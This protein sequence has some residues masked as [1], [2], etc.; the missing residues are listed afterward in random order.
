MS[1]MLKTKFRVKDENHSIQIQ[2]ALFE[3]G[4]D[5]VSYNIPYKTPQYTRK[6]YLYVND[7]GQ[8][9]HGDSLSVFDDF[10]DYR[11]MRIVPVT[12]FEFV[13]VEE[14]IVVCGK[15]VKKKDYMQAVADLEEVP[16]Y[17]D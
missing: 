13:E 10:A 5:W 8:L 7:S 6:P 12:T 3:L 15:R 9:M 4:F 2:K 17:A 1:D 11:E 16:N 14:T